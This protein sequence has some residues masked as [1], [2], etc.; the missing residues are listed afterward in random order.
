M[1]KTPKTTTKR[2]GF[3]LVEFTLVGIPLM[4]LTISIIEASIAM[5]QYHSMMYANEV[6]ARYAAMHGKG[7]TQNGNTCTIT[8]GTLAKM[9]A[10]Q[11]PSLDTSKLDVTLYSNSGN[12]P[13]APITA[14]YSSNTQFPSNTDN[15]VGND[16]KFVAS[17]PIYNPMPL[18]WP[19][20]GQTAGGDFTLGSTTRQRIVF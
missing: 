15:A 9:I 6:V 12:T 13:C 20:A 7:C 16:V 17:Y 3:A 4:F 1:N 5:W 14:C 18:M 10:N 8:V 11:A 2:R 19:G